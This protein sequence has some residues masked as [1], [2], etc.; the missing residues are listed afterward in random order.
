MAARVQQHVI[1]IGAGVGGLV[2]A[3]LLAHQGVQVTVLERAATP[4][5]KMRRIAV[6][7]AEVDSGPTVFTMRPVFQDIFNRV[8]ETLESHLTLTPL[9]VLAR[10]A[11]Q[12]GET[13]DLFADAKRSADAIGRFAGA[14]EARRFECFC[15]DTRQLISTLASIYIGP[16]KPTV[17]GMIH[18]LGPAGLLQLSALGPYATPFATLASSLKRRFSDP[19]L[20]QLFA[21]YATYCGSSPY[22][23]PA[24]LMMIAQVEMD[25]VWQVE[26]GMSRVA[27]VMA[28]LAERKGAT[29]RYEA[30]VAEILQRNDQA[31]GVRLQS[32][33][34]LQADAVVFNGDSS[35]LPQGLLGEAAQKAVPPVPQTARS[36]SA[37]TW[38][39]K[40]KTSS[41]E[42]MPHNVFFDRDYESEFRDIFKHQRLPRNATVYVC[43]QD[44]NDGAQLNAPQS[45]ERLLCLV[46]A[47]AVGDGTQA[48]TS[49]S[50]MEI[51]QCEQRSFTLMERLGLSIS[52][53][54]SNTV[55]TTP[56]QF[57]AL[58]PGTGGALYGQANH[59]PL[60]GWLSLFKRPGSASALPGLFLAGG[61]VHPGPGVPMAAM[62]GQ[63][64]AERVMAHLASTKQL[65][66]VATSGG[67]STPSATT[68]S[69]A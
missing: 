50:S 5:G 53:T 25:G 23:S 36:L 21:R 51:E 66:P 34:V 16:Q 6:D 47:P 49:L 46:N 67:T 54:A 62:S 19:R 12:P 17:L 56:Q 68:A 10:H 48:S 69:T 31:C 1:V 45:E 4:G 37:L 58:F 40:A 27:Q 44:R 30:Q 9:Q 59:G 2:S 39:I 8:G 18:S 11:W 3:L 61:S 22:Q 20:I 64:A 55:L 42:L 52:R 65:H 24:T 29:L 28:K 60:N 7:G 35:A 43:A 41:F 38:S 57:H 15:T 14:T 13:L 32:G 33:E 26:G 63:L